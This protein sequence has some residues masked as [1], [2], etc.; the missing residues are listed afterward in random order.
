VDNADLDK[1]LEQLFPVQRELLRR[2]F[3]EKLEAEETQLLLG[4]SSRRE[5]NTEILKALVT[6]R[7]NAPDLQTYYNP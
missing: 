4:F 7:A 1:R 6:L 3:Q 5:L 2:R